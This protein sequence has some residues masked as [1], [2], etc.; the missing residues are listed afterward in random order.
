MATIDMTWLPTLAANGALEDLT[1]ISG[2]QL[3][4][5]PIADQYTQ[6]AQDAMH[7]GDQMVA[8]LY[9]LR[10]LRPLLPEG[11]VRPEG[12][13]GP[14]EL[15]RPA[16]GCQAAGRSVQGGW[17]ERQVPDRHP[18]EQ[19]PLL[20]VPVP[21]WRLA[22]QRRQHPGRVQLRG[23]RERGQHPEGD[24]RR[25]QRPVLAGCQQRPDPGDQ[26]RRGRDVPGRA[27]LHGPPQD[28]RAR[29][30]RQVGGRD[31]AVL[32]AAR[33]LSRRHRPRDPGPGPAQGGGL[34]VHPVP[35]PARE[36][37]SACSPMPARPRPRRPLSRAPS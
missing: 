31:G 22:P 3:N 20:A 15:G 29:T 2:G 35:A 23:G 19:L 11:P 8:M 28:R 5:T 27:V 18:P 1:P 24:P 10:H 17:Q 30:V 9:R 6:G 25:W 14:E 36:R 4:G 33:E 7:F 16:G 37:R 13:R 21:G 32:Q 26:V 34:A 12:D